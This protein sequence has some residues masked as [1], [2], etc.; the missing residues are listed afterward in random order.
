MMQNHHFPF[1]QI[2]QLP[3][4]QN[5]YITVNLF[6]SKLI[7]QQT[8]LFSFLKTPVEK[9]MQIISERMTAMPSLQS[10]F[11]APIT[12]QTLPR[13]MPMDIMPDFEPLMLQHIR[14]YFM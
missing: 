2:W 3:I 9:Y 11:N 12:G 7:I 13:I 6:T 14:Y 4:W 10:Q 1:K 8:T 5:T